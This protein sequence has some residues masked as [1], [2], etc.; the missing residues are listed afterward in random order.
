MKDGSN[1]FPVV[2]LDWNRKP[3]TVLTYLSGFGHLCWPVE[4]T[5]ARCWSSKIVTRYIARKCNLMTNCVKIGNTNVG[6]A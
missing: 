2:T 1:D 5:L 3:N 6:K 4:K